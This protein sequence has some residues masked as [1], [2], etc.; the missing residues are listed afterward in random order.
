MPRSEKWP[1]KV[2][3]W[4]A[5][6]GEIMQATF[7]QVFEDGD[8]RVDSPKRLQNLL[9]PPSILKLRLFSTKAAC[10]RAVIKRLRTHIEGEREQLKEQ[11]ANLVRKEATLVQHQQRLKRLVAR[12]KTSR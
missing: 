11:Q 12:T 2:T 5:W 7:S 3:G 10:L 1:K 8:F 6:E 9:L 4:F